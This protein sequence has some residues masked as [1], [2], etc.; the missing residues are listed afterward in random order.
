MLARDETL[1]SALTPYARRLPQPQK[2]GDPDLRNLRERQYIATMRIVDWAQRNQAAVVDHWADLEAKN[3]QVRTEDLENFGPKTKKVRDLHPRFWYNF[4]KNEIPV[5]PIDK[6]DLVWSKP[7]GQ[8]QV[9][10]IGKNLTGTKDN[11]TWPALLLNK[12]IA[13]RVLKYRAGILARGENIANAIDDNGI[14]DWK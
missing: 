3:W 2:C 12:Q 1:L 5:I 9:S 11:D 4:I 13:I 10:H 7:L 6:L 8:Q 14:V